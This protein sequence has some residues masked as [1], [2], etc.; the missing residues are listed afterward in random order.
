MVNE[1]KHRVMLEQSEK[2]RTIEISD[3]LKT[4]NNEDRDLINDE[5]VSPLYF[6]DIREQINLYRQ[7]E[8]GEIHKAYLKEEFLTGA[9]GNNNLNMIKPERVSALREKI[10]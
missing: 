4:L 2:K 6:K 5:F 10:N 1:S 8:N 3:F 7:F 9:N